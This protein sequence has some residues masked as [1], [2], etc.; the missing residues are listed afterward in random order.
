M[1][2]HGQD[3]D[4]LPDV[5]L[6]AGHHDQP[7]IAVLD[8]GVSA[9][10]KFHAGG[11]GTVGVSAMNAVRRSPSEERAMNQQISLGRCIPMYLRFLAVRPIESATAVT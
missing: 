2:V 4:D 10:P 9:M 8:A 6:L 3:G 11:H 5:N 1:E 7:V